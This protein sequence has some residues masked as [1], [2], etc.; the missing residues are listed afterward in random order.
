MGTDL[1]SMIVIDDQMRFWHCG[2]CKTALILRCG[3]QMCK[4]VTTGRIVI[5]CL[6]EQHKQLHTKL[7]EQST[8]LFHFMTVIFM[9]ILSFCDAFA[10]YCHV[11]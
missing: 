4:T 8:K 1:L 9:Y 7:F 6:T 10:F 5:Y 3:T 11:I 2:N